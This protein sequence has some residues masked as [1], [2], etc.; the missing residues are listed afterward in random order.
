MALLALGGLTRSEDVYKEVAEVET[1]SS[2]Y[3]GHG[4]GGY[5]GGDHHGGGYGGHGDGG[6]GG[7]DHGG[8]GYG[9]GG[10]EDSGYGGGYGGGD[11]YGGYGSDGYHWKTNCLQSGE[12]FVYLIFQTYLFIY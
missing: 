10:Y 2:G 4:D 3:G 12:A 6:Y 5:G 7:G 8:G 11:G 1:Y 9:G